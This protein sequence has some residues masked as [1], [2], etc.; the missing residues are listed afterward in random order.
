M[1][2]WMI[3]GLLI[4]LF[5]LFVSYFFTPFLLFIFL[6]SFFLLSLFGILLIFLEHEKNGLTLLISGSAAFFPVGLLLAITSHQ[7]FEKLFL[8]GHLPLD[9]RNDDEHENKEK[10]LRHPLF[11]D[12]FKN[13]FDLFFGA[14]F[15]LGVNYLYF[16]DHLSLPGSS[17]LLALLSVVSL[18]LHFSGLW[19]LTHPLILPL[20]Q[21]ILLQ[22]GLLK[23]ALSIPYDSIIA[24]NEKG[25]LSFL[26][27]DKQLSLQL[28]IQQFDPQQWNLFLHWLQQRLASQR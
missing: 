4:D 8:Q 6:A 18:W 21:K 13:Y 1:N 25:Q 12:P 2:R 23:K 26:T 14:T 10:L 11:T 9:K 24:C 28:P 17:L 7:Q 20:E 15:F 16:A 5:A 22:C 27:T 19:K 3:L